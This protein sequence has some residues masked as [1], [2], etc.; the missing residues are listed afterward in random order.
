MNKKLLMSFLLGSF[1]LLL[2]CESSHINSKM[3]SQQDGD[4]EFFP[5]VGNA[6]G[7]AAGTKVEFSADGVSFNM[8]YVPGGFTFPTG[9][10]DDGAPATVA[11]AYLIGETEVTYELWYKVITWAV[12]NGYTFANT[13][14]EGKLGVNGAAPTAAKDHPVTFVGWRDAMVFG[15]A[16]TEWYNAN[17][18]T[19]YT[20]AYYIDADY[21]TPIRAS[22]DDET[23]CFTPGCQ[24]NPYI[25]A[26]ASGFRLPTSKEWEL[27]ARYKDGISWTYGTWASGATADYNDATATQLVDWYSLNS[28]NVTHAV[29]GKLPNA[30]GLYDMSGNV[31]E[32]NFE[33][34]AP[35]DLEHDWTRLIRGG[36]WRWGD[37]MQV[38]NTNDGATPWF[39]YYEVGFRFVRTDL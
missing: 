9:F 33:Y 27:A 16:L 2:G 26:D 25:K 38:G 10:Y 11:N 21:T 23:L 32:W 36:S 22:V 14:R 8:A 24:D 12:S 29:K 28:S 17:A 5:S 37:Y 31:W 34:R 1:V 35:D 7:M 20:C 15:N 4:G 39:A 6:T 30:L 19:N 18:G 13:G 3:V